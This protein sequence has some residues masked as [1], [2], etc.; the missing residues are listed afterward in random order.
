VSALGSLAVAAGLA[1]AVA[2]VATDRFAERVNSPRETGLG[3]LS[4][5]QP[6]GAV[7]WIARER[8][9]GPIAHD[10]ADGGYLIARLWPDYPVMVDGRLEVFGAETF[11]RLQI[12]GPEQFRALDAEH[13]FG[14]VLVHYSLVDARELLWW[15]HLNPNWRL[16]FVDDTAA[17][18]VR[19][20]PESGRWPELQVDAPDLF[21]PL[22]AERSA[23]DRLRR[24]ARINFLVSMRRY[25]DALPLWEE[26]IARYPEL[27][28]ARRL[29]A[30]LLG[31][32]GFAAA[33]EALLREELS[34]H[35]DEPDVI[36]HMA[37]L[38]WRSG[39]AAE[40]RTLLDRALQLDPNHPYA[41]Q[42]RAQVAEAQGDVEGAAHYRERLR[43]MTGAAEWMDRA[44]GR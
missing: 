19:D 17:L 6:E 11:A 31:E 24:Q 36:V 29:H 10:M 38:R 9:S 13:R 18:Y 21:P 28:Q 5:F 14:A 41:L 23:S 4:F 25:E 37:D 33:A 20:G 12:Q 43:A 1:L 3:T 26:T 34:L 42:L 8:P 7:D 40:A 16:V 30:H 27:P 32:L 22:P 39:D 35:P 44:G 15:L 2:D